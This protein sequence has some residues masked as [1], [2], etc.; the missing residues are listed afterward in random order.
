MFTQRDYKRNTY[1]KKEIDLCPNYCSL[2]EVKKKTRQHRNKHTETRQ[3]RNKHT[4]TESKK[5]YVKKQILQERN[6]PLNEPLQPERRML[7]Q[8]RKTT[9]KQSK[10]TLI[11]SFSYLIN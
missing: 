9:Q 7:T 6:R 5:D 8:R 11:I 10:E 2:K 1:H 4:E 3:H